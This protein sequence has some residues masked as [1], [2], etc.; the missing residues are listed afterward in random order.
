MT[1]LIHS[2]SEFSD[3][4]L[5]ALQI[6]GARNIAEVGA[7][8]GGTSQQLAAYARV[9]GGS[10]TSID[11]A[12]KQEFIDWVNQTPEVRHIAK[13]S[14]DAMPELSGIDAWVIDGDH[15][16]YTVIEELRI[17]DRL[18]RRD[19]K[20]LFALMHDVSWPCARRDCYYAPDRIPEEHRHPYSFEGGVAL[21]SA[22][23]TPNRGFRGAGSFAW[24]LHEGGPRNG[25]LTAVEDFLDEA[26]TDERQLAW[27]HVPA[28]FGLGVLFDSSAPW[29]PALAEMIMPWHNNK[30][31]ASLEAN[32]LRNYLAV[33][34]W[35]DRAAEAA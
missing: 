18:A 28:V 30:L 9:T 11:P 23:C 10:L 12:P 8:F 6:A 7:E 16:Y 32:R 34:D 13:P 29:A 24:A 14:H 21:G 2:M 17:A 22:A 3:I 20:P 27:A 25:V 26:R 4:I 1:L 35:Q 33:I 15:N 19:G 31:L 5:Q